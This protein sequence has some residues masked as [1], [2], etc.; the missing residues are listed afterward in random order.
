VRYRFEKNRSGKRSRLSLI[1]QVLSRVRP[2]FVKVTHG[3]LVFSEDHRE[4]LV[5]LYD[6]IL[7]MVLEGVSREEKVGRVS[8]NTIPDLSTFRE[9]EV[10]VLV[11]LERLQD[12]VQYFVSLGLVTVEKLY[13]TNRLSEDLYFKYRRLLRFL[14]RFHGMLINVSQGSST[15]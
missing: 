5:R 12:E 11:R 2:V 4:K 7:E 13:L 15:D 6:Q 8:E 10:T 3:S 9:D 14:P 1:G